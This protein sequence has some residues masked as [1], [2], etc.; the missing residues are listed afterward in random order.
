M[1][2]KILEAREMFVH[3]R[4]L[5]EDDCLSMIA[6]Q[7][8]GIWVSHSVMMANEVMIVD[9]WIRFWL[10]I[11]DVHYRFVVHPDKLMFDQ[12][13]KSIVR[14]HRTNVET[15]ENVDSSQYFPMILIF[16]DYH[17]RSLIDEVFSNFVDSHNEL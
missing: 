9:D 4:D 5:E 13:M 6:C 2:E 12:S 11:V 1:I 3:S 15:I 10:L 14:Q 8:Q 7:L 17:L 16:V